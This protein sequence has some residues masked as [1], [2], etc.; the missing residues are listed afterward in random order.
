MKSLSFTCTEAFP[1]SHPRIHPATIV[2][3]CGGHCFFTGF[4]WFCYQQPVFSPS[5]FVDIFNVYYY[6]SFG[7][8]IFF[9]NGSGTSSWCPLPL[10]SRFTKITTIVIADGEDCSLFNSYLPIDACGVRFHLP[11]RSAHWK[12]MRNG[13]RIG[14]HCFI[15][16]HVYPSGD[17]AFV[18]GRTDSCSASTSIIWWL[19]DD[20]VTMVPLDITFSLEKGLLKSSQRKLSP[21]I[22]LLLQDLITGRGL[23][24]IVLIL[25]L[26][27]RTGDYSPLVNTHELM[28]IESIWLSSYSYV[29][30]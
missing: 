27:I 1:L 23:I 18:C 24:L 8:F 11:H 3:Q 7:T 28:Y 2:G 17:H 9:A 5:N 16:K 29:W 22:S 30:D 6:T 10:H 4:A 13:H 15:P 25:F 19:K 12:A 26:E 20:H 14:S 21:C